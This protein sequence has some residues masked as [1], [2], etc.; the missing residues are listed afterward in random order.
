MTNGPPLTEMSKGGIRFLQRFQASYNGIPKWLR[1]FPHDSLL[2]LGDPSGTIRFQF[3]NSGNSKC[4]SGY[5]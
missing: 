5:D 3:F 4:L 2:C 1:G